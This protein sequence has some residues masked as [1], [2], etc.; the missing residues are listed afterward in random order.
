MA[1]K[2]VAVKENSDKGNSFNEYQVHCKLMALAELLGNVHNSQTSL[3]EHACYGIE[4]LL[5]EIADEVR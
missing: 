5:R 1:E 2:G 4:L 3:G